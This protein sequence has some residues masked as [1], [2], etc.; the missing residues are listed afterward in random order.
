MKKTL[1]SL[2]L[3]L[4]MLP[5]SSVYIASD[6]PYTNVIVELT[7]PAGADPYE[8]AESCALLASKL[9]RGLE[10]DY[11]YDTLLCGF[12]AEL[13]CSAVSLLESCEFVDSI[14]F[15]ASYEPMNSSYSDSEAAMIAAKMA[16]VDAAHAKGLSGNGIKVAVIDSGFDVSHPAFSA[17]VTDTLD[18]SIFENRLSV[19]KPTAIRALEHDHQPLSILRY[20]SKIPFM[21]DYAGK[22]T[23]VFSSIDHGTHVAG[24]IGAAPT[25]ISTMKGI[26]PDCQLLLMKVFNDQGSSTLDSVLISALED[27]LKLGADVI[28]MS[29][30]HYA[31]SSQTSRIIGLDNLIRRLEE[32]GCVV[33]CAAGN[34]SVTTERGALADE[35][36]ANYPLASY[37]DYGTVSSPSAS[38]YAL[39]VA[40]V[41]NSVYYGNYIRH[42]ANGDFH[43][44][45]TDTNIANEIL[46][47]TFREY[48][49]GKILEYVPIPGVGEEKDYEGIDVSGKLAL[50]MRGTISFAE[51]ANIAAANGAVGVIVYNNADDGYVNMDLGG[52]AIPAIFVNNADGLSLISEKTH[53][54]AVEKTS[55]AK[56]HPDKIGKVSDYS[57]RGTTPSLKLKPDIS[58]VGG[59]V[60]STLPGGEYGGISGTSMA[61]P[62]IAGICALLYENAK[63]GE[64][65]SPDT[66]VSEIRTTL[67]NTAIPVLNDKGVEYSPRQQGAGLVNLE[68]ALDNKIR[69][70]ATHNFSPKAE[71]GDRLGGSVNFDITL[72]NTGNSP[73]TLNLGAT[74]TS[75]G[76]TKLNVKDKTEYFSTMEAVADSA[77]RITVNDSENLNRFAPDYTP[78]K[79]TL[80]AG[81][82]LV[83]PLHIEFDKEY[84]T[85][86]NEIF[87]NGHFVE[88]FIYCTSESFNVSMPYMGYWGDFSGAPVLDGNVYNGEPV[89]F[90]GSRL[91][92]PLDDIHITAGANIYTSPY[93]YDEAAVSFSPN[94]DGNADEILFG[95]SYLR[96]FL[97]AKMEITDRGGNLITES[98]L[99]Y[100]TKT[101]G[102][103]E[104]TIF[105]FFWDGGDDIYPNYKMPDG[106]YTM[107]IEYTL[108]D[109]RDTKQTYSYGITLDTVYPTAEKISLDGNILSISASDSNG[110]FGIRIYEGVFDG[111]YSMISAENTAEFNISEYEG[112]KLYYDIVDYAF[113][114]TVGIIDLTQLQN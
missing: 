57:S 54:I 78:Y 51:K 6:E 91:Y 15:C 67:L 24:I 47:E 28:N 11:I 65:Y 93:T 88:G 27:A 12:S 32:N 21:Y 72:K 34:D 107:T 103:D 63:N 83:L 8:H 64:D 41:N 55:I 13:P 106:K 61:A 40:A 98:T 113:N 94:G 39:A 75:D 16:G 46:P 30:G 101:K 85:K 110:I 52:A 81:E 58:G 100:T 1:L 109:G 60:Y 9:I 68:A 42:G 37:T 111:A 69:L 74:L 23:D 108:D 62:Q 102:I 35:I 73:I 89:L 87:T 3:M 99:G 25:Q 33:V 82:E 50:V 66:I 59:S 45:Y 53:T 90:K 4:T 22:D 92:V 48:F 38:E 31:G 44:E 20:N 19:E 10:Y 36:G 29:V 43:F 86:L 49:D 96:N 76:Y 7:P 71:L 105:A 56:P 26:A 17:E 95:T 97:K 79:I 5:L 80:E 104:T 77:S 70:T 114:T 14:Y 112:S 18:F 84:H 2:L